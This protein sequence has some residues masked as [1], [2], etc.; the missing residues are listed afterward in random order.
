MIWFSTLALAASALALLI[1]LYS[2]R[3]STAAIREANNPSQILQLKQLVIE[4]DS[5]LDEHYKKNQA[6]A[7][8][9]AKYAKQIGGNN[10]PESPLTNEAPTAIHDPTHVSVE[11]QK[12][13]LNRLA[14]SQ[15][16]FR[17]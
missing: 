10:V 13:E 9:Y 8:R 12:A 4:Y 6:Q 15:G 7:A 14:L 2:L 17:G 5:A 3:R 1:G 16:F 11:D